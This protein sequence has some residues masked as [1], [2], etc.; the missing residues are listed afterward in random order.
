MYF[1]LLVESERIL[2]EDGLSTDEKKLEMA[3]ILAQKAFVLQKK[4]LMKEALN[5]YQQVLKTK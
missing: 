5:I 2:T 1:I 3:P 4:G